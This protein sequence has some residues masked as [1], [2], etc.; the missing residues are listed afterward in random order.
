[1]GYA[2][3]NQVL[4]CLLTGRDVSFA[5]RPGL[6]VLGGVSL[7]VG[8]GEFVCILG[9]NGCGKTTLLRC[10]MGR[11]RP[12]GGEVRLD[13]RDVRKIPTRQLARRLAYVPQQGGVSLA[14]PAEEVVLT[15]RLSR[16][17][18]LGLAGRSDLDIVHSAMKMTETLQFRGRALGELSGGEAQRVMIARAIAQQPGLCLLDEPTSQLDIRNQM[19]IYQMMRRLASDWKMAVICV[20]HDVNL[21]GRFADRLILMGRGRVVAAGQPG[22]V[23]TEQVMRETYGLDVE[24]IPVANEPPMVRAK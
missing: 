3:E 20:S 11:L 13:G 7:S 2:D 1:M 16:C 15:G 12:A 4:P 21:A 18:L 6:S 8:S 22:E 19:L 5:Y 9:P 10:L 23:I 17:G 24:L 14:M